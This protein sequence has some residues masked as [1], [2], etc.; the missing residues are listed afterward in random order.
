[1][2]N[3]IKTEIAIGIILL[4]AIIVGGFIWLSG[5]QQTGQNQ[6][7]TPTPVAQQP[8]QQPSNVNKTADW[9]TYK[10]DKY[11]FEI[12]FTDAWKNYKT[13]ETGDNQDATIQIQIPTTDPNWKRFGNLATPLDIMIFTKA[14]WAQASKQALAPNLITQN[15]QYVFA[16]TGWQDVPSDFGGSN[17]IG[18]QKL[19][20]DKVISSFKLTQQTNDQ[21]VTNIP[22]SWINYTDSKYGFELRLP[23]KPA[24]QVSYNES[25]KELG[26]CQKVVQLTDTGGNKN[27]FVGGLTIRKI[28]N[29]TDVSK[30]V[31]VMNLYSAAPQIS[32]NGITWNAFY[33][34]KQTLIGC[35]GATF[36]TLMPSGKDI[37][38]ISEDSNTQCPGNPAKSPSIDFLKQAL[39]TFKFTK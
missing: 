35:E 3:K 24:K 34:P 28:V 13:V 16:Y 21:T 5:K 38:E 32:L 29:C 37:I 8:A 27:L 11:G 17:S 7:A 39:S 23:E 33:N 19:E 2:N 22:A 36:Q 18:Y 12:T 15:N 31:N 10:N 20:F 9:H 30:Q 14:Q 4:I 25:N 26:Q 6:P 1:M